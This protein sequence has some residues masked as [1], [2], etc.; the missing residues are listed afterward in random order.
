[1]RGYCRKPHATLPMPHKEARKHTPHT[2]K[3]TIEYLETMNRRLDQSKIKQRP[4]DAC[5]QR[6]QF[7]TARVLLEKL[8]ALVARVMWQVRMR[9]HR[10]SFVLVPCSAVRPALTANTRVSSTNR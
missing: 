9:R 1:M 10:V 2:L 5:L 7:R 8:F 4:E 6:Q 3:V